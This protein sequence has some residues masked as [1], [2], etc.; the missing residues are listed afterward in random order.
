IKEDDPRFQIILDSIVIKKDADL[1]LIEKDR[2]QF[3][4]PNQEAKR[5]L[6]EA[7][8]DF[9][10]KRIVFD[11][12]ASFW[13]SESMLNDMNKAVTKFMSWLVEYSG[14]EVEMINHMGKSSSQSKDM[15]QFAGRGGSGLPSNSRISRVLRPLPP[16]EFTEMTGKELVGDQSAILCQV[17]KFSD[18]SVLFNKPFIIIRD[19]YLFSR[20]VLT[21]QKEKEVETRLSDTEKVFTFVKEER[22][23][24]RWPTKKVIIGHFARSGNPLPKTRVETA[25]HLLQYTGHM[26]EKLQLIDNPD[27]SIRDQAFTITDLDGREV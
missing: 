26:G 13:G 20:E 14:A 4:H 10:P 5:K 25:I 11:P 9:K 27:Q 3:L 2:Q 23:Q 12:I 8:D 18:G 1:C 19:G 16:E 22:E 21:P 24:N 15:T 7:V 6:Q 17:N